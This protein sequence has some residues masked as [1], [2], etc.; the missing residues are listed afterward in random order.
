MS[1]DTD[2]PVAYQDYANTLVGTEDE[3]WTL[4]MR[5][6]HGREKHTLKEWAVVLDRHRHQPA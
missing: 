1:N 5:R 3:I 2:F 6:Q 4:H